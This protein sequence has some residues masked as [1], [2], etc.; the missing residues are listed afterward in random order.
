MSATNK[1]FAYVFNTTREDT[2][3]AKVLS[4]W[5][6]TDA[7]T[8]PSLAGF[9]AASRNRIRQLR[10]LLVA[11]SMHFT[12][13]SYNLDNH[14]ADLLTATLIQHFPAVIE[15]YPMCPYTSR[16][17]LYL[18]TLLV[19]MPEV[20]SWSLSLTRSAKTPNSDKNESPFSREIQLINQQNIVISQLL[21]ANREQAA[22]IE[23]LE[24][25]G[26]EEA[27]AGT[28]SLTNEGITEQGEEINLANDS[29]TA[30]NENRKRKARSSSKAAAALFFEWYT[31]TP[32]LWEKCDDRQYKSQS[33]Q[34]VAFMKLFHPAGLKLNPASRNYADDVLRIGRLAEENMFEFMGI[35]GIKRNFGTGLLKQLRVL[36]RS[37]AFKQRFQD[38][39]IRVTTTKIVD[40]APDHTKITY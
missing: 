25:L 38:Y 16:M 21:E 36:H 3:V 5:K 32:R 20:L 24:K 23:E 17:R 18:G 35:R 6:S 2:K 12:A 7:P 9:E 26:L 37:G 4:G 15:R 31:K 22:K 40:P 13:V 8:I 10:D 39:Q 28:H 19:E 1:A 27:A 29:S 33:K 30:G 34:I 14:V 11:S